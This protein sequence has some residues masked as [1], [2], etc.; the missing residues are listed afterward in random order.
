MLLDHATTTVTAKK[1]C[2]TCAS[3]VPRIHTGINYVAVRSTAGG[4]YSVGSLLCALARP[5]RIRRVA[6]RET[7]RTW[8][9]SSGAT[10]TVALV[11]NESNPIQ[12]YKKQ[13]II[14]ITTS[15]NGYII[16]ARKTIQLKVQNSKARLC[17]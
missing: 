15:K 11:T 12:T 13:P 10:S 8:R 7:Q 2:P 4:D 5:C 17:I 14:Y 3:R 6:P 16:S 9:T 1:P